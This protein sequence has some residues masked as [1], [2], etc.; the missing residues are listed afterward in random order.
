[1]IIPGFFH[2]TLLAKLGLYGYAHGVKAN[3]CPL[4]RTKSRTF[5]IRFTPAV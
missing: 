4:N 2:C 1:M 5:V 3:G